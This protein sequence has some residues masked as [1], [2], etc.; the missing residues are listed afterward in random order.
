MRIRRRLLAAL[1]AA[2]APAWA[3]APAALD[4]FVRPD[5][6]HC[7]ACHQ[8]PANAGPASRATL[9]P[10]LEGERMRA[11]GKAGIREAIEDPMRRNPDTVMPP[12]GR[13][14]I[15][16]PQEIARL[17]DYLHALP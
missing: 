6:G 17:V 4:L 11:L 12:Y 2:A 15:L 14:H 1:L 8:L 7:I 16:E 5:K 13:H 10:V 9:G 3:Q